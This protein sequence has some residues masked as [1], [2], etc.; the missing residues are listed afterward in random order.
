MLDHCLSEPLTAL[1]QGLLLLVSWGFIALLINSSAHT[2]LRGMAYLKR[3]HSI[4]CHRCVYFTGHYQLKCTVHPS[5]AL[6]E[7]AIHCPD[8]IPCA[9]SREKVGVLPWKAVRATQTLPEASHAHSTPA[10]NQRH[11]PQAS[12]YQPTVL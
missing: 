5:E 11:L 1:F 6:T 4:P 7:Q 2:L 12:S 3:L 9:R 10:H 8:C